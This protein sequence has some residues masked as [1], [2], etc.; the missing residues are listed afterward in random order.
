M[1]SPVGGATAAAQLTN[2][3]VN[4]VSRLMEPQVHVKLL[5]SCGSHRWVTET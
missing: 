3:S 4:L 2:I 5:L 1:V